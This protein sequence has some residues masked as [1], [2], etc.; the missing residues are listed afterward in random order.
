M[1]QRDPYDDGSCYGRFGEKYEPSCPRA[2][3]QRDHP[4]PLVQLAVGLE[5]VNDDDK[6]IEL[7]HEEITKIANAVHQ[8]YHGANPLDL[9][10]VGWRECPMNICV[11]AQQLIDPA[12]KRGHRS[13]RLS[14]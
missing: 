13:A 12:R 7:L 1:P 6:E 9:C 5:E 14:S 10:T 2:V 8:A 11:R 3:R 4:S